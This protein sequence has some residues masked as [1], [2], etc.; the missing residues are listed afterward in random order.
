M[1]TRPTYWMMI[2]AA[3]SLLGVTPSARAQSPNSAFNEALPELDS[4]PDELPDDDAGNKRDWDA[5]L[6]EPGIMSGVAPPPSKSLPDADLPPVDPSLG[7]APTRSP[8]AWAAS[9]RDAD[10]VLRLEARIPKKIVVYTEL[11]KKGAPKMAPIDAKELAANSFVTLVSK[12]QLDLAYMVNAGTG[13]RVA[14]TEKKDELTRARLLLKLS[15]APIAIRCADT[16]KPCVLYGVSGKKVR[17]INV[18]RLENPSDGPTVRRWLRSLF[19]YDA[20]VV[21]RDGE[22][23][24]VGCVAPFSDLPARV[25]VLRNTERYYLKSDL[26]RNVI[27]ELIPVRRAGPWAVFRIDGRGVNG[28]EPV[29]PIGAKL[30]FE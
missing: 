22:Y 9:L 26:R 12:D 24:L 27:A 15:R 6:I 29:V 19:G 17:Q 18:S 25:A 30:I 2:V 4:L 28:N 14:P 1:V 13:G 3:A 5:D 8:S 20:V 16:S 11:Q 23:V 10:G 7:A 21:S